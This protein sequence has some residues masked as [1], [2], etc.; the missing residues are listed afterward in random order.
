MTS[1]LNWPSP[2]YRKPLATIKKRVLNF[3]TRKT[4]AA[5]AFL[6]CLFLAQFTVAQE[7]PKTRILF[8]FD[9]SNS[10]NG[11]WQSGQKITIAQRLLSQAL[12]SLATIENLELAFRVYG[13]QKDYLHGQDCDDTELIVPFGRNNAYRIKSEL[14]KIKPKGTTPIAATLEKAAGDFPTCADCRNIIILITDGIEECNGDPCAVSLALMKKGIT[15]KPF[16]IGI[17]LDVEFR[18]TFE[19]VGSYFDASD[20]ANFRNVLNIVISQALNST[21]AQVNLLDVNNDPTET[22]VNMTFYDQNTKRVLYNY[23]HTMNSKG[24]PDTLGLDPVHTYRIAAHTIPPREVEN[25]EIKPGTHNI[26]GISTP[27]GDL[28]ISMGGT[29]DY[30]GIETII[31]QHGSG[32]TLHVQQVGTSERYIVGKYDLEILTLPRTLLPNVEIKQSHTTSIEL[33]Q[34]GVATFSK[35]GYGYGSVYLETGNGLQWVT[36]LGI[37][38]EREVLNL[39]PGNYVAVFRPKSARQ[40]IF[41]VERKFRVISGASVAVKLN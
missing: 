26:I 4:L 16:V 31:R 5:L 22:N 14:K 38:K 27:Q 25:V 32:K 34:P 33:P 24:H 23:V 37:T 20:E 18:K 30:S 17:G 10:M 19:C 13:H 15:L 29:G 35:N 9:A 6:M 11:F 36:N 7:V 12:D 40:S 41:T 3:A 21:T 8:I 1:N 28:S 2:K 39:Q